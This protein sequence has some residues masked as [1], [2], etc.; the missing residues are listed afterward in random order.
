MSAAH[1]EWANLALY[2]NETSGVGHHSSLKVRLT[3]ILQADW[4]NLDDVNW[5][6]V[7]DSASGRFGGRQCDASRRKYVS[8]DLLS[9]NHPCV[10]FVFSCFI[11]CKSDVLCIV[12]L[13]YNHSLVVRREHWAWSSNVNSVRVHVSANGTYN[14][15][16]CW[17]LFRL[18]W[19]RDFKI[20][21]EIFNAFRLMQL[22][23]EIRCGLVWFG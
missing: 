13:V 5:E 17:G 11:C 10:L 22:D 2:K 3:K 7:A 8:A 20:H 14:V 23:L 18:Q 16:T 4:R 12:V 21:G 15:E 9:A 19:F 1:L 6:A